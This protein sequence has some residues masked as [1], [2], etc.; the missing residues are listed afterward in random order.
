[1]RWVLQVDC[2]VFFIMDFCIDSVFLK[3]FFKISLILITDQGF[4]MPLNFAPMPH[5]PLPGPGPGSV[6]HYS[7]L[8][9]FVDCQ[10]N[11]R[12]LNA[13]QIGF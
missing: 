10:Q 7:A 13:K 11:A 12:A 4:N 9:S 2:G 5:L 3:W 6:T 8:A 1:M